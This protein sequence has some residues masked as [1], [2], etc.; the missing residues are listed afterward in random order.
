MASAHFVTSC[1]WLSVS[2]LLA[3]PVTS[4][5]QVATPPKAP[6]VAPVR[7]VEDDYHGT[8]VTD[9]YRYM[10]KQ[11]DPEVQAWFK[12]QNDFTRSALAAI[13]GRDR[14]LARI[15]ELDESVPRVFAERLPGDLYIL[16]KRNPGDEVDRLYVHKGL[17]GRDELLVDPQKI[18]LSTS[19]Q[20]KGKNAIAGWAISNDAKYITFGVTPGG[21]ERDNEWHVMEIATGRETGDVIAGVGFFP[22]LPNWL[23]DNRSFVYSRLQKLSPGAPASEIMQKVRV[24]RHVLGRDTEK[25]EPVFGFE[26][27]PSIAVDPVQYAGAQTQPDTD[28]ALATLGTVAP[29]PTFYVGSANKIGKEPMEW[30]KVASPEDRVGQM[31][32]HGGDLYAMTFKNASRY[33]VIRIDARTLDIASAEVVV[34]RSDAVVTGIQP[35]LD[36]LYVTL[37][38]GGVGRLLRVP[39]GP[40][41]KSEEVPLPVQGSVSIV[42]D[43]RLSGAQVFMTSWTS[44]FR[45]FIYDPATR[46]MTET[47]FQAVGPHDRP[48]DIESVEV[49]V[50]SYDGTKVPLSIIH[51]K[52]MRL[53]GTN[54]TFLKGYGA[55]GFSYDPYYDPTDVAWYEQGGVQA[56]CHVRGGGEYGEDWHLAGKGATKPNTWKD[57]IACAQYLIDNKYTSPAR[58]GGEGVSAGGILIGRAITERPDLFAAAIDDVGMSDALRFETSA[59]GGQ[60]VSEFG[61]TKTK[62]GFAALFAMSSYDHVEFKARYPAILLTTGM[63]DPRVDSWQMGKMTARLQAATASGKPVLLRV[64]YAGGHA[65]IGSTQKQRREKQADDWSFLLWQFGVLAFQPRETAKVSQ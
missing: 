61:S 54:P 46:Q 12:G 40:R 30:R 37:R 35:A 14:L 62:E 11:E 56:I 25:D 10:E 64:D 20:G 59:G 60:N 18:T 34:P 6:P 15:E 4:L 50:T 13:P 7:P 9:P 36:A 38:D 65:G 31:A 2:L 58:L 41:P 5:A 22:F 55:Y 44:T 53:D 32:V 57:F 28:Y 26:A 8:E 49:K 43:P 1:F 19:I 17:K 52:G 51:P 29:N 3:C 21:A 39:Y 23:P 48:D 24:Y 42:T 33:Q 45:D 63:N 16:S 47:G 27:V